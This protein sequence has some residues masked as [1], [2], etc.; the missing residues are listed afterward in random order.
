MPEI[1]KRLSFSR[2]SVGLY[3]PMREMRRIPSPVISSAGSPPVRFWIRR[4]C[5]CWKMPWANC[6]GALSFIPMTV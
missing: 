4:I 1:M 2:T 6:R 3:W 5:P